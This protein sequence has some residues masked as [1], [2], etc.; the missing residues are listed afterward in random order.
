MPTLAELRPVR[1][2]HVIAPRRDTYS[3]ANAL[4]EASDF[5]VVTVWWL[6]STPIVLVFEVTLKTNK[7]SAS[8]TPVSPLLLNKL[9]TPGES[10]TTPTSLHLPLTII[11]SLLVQRSNMPIPTYLKDAAAVLDNVIKTTTNPYLLGIGRVISNLVEVTPTFHD[12]T[13]LTYKRNALFKTFD[14]RARSVPQKHDLTS[15]F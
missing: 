8:V 9:I 3:G 13:W 7:D 1:S 12:R 2:S 5:D 14:V 15:L 11:C 4:I 10:V 6:D